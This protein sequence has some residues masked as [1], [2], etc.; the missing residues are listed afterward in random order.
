MAN[1]RRLTSLVMAICSNAVTFA[2][3]VGHET[4]RIKRP[5]SR[6]RPHG[7]ATLV[8]SRPPLSSGLNLMNP[9]RN[10]PRKSSPVSGLVDIFPRSLSPDVSSG[11]NNLGASPQM[12]QPIA[13]T[14]AS[15]QIRS[16]RPNSIERM[17]AAANAPAIPV[18]SR[19]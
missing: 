9:E 13:V 11:K 12:D 3:T 8:G 7:G 18:S 1:A 2:L 17:P 15:G 14:I 16:P 10:G 5:R 6:D 4:G 19:C